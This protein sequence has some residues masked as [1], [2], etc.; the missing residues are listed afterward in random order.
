M[1]TKEPLRWLSELDKCGW[2]KDWT[3][4]VKV[5]RNKRTRRVS[6]MMRIKLFKEVFGKDV[7]NHARSAIGS[8]SLPLDVSVEVEAIVT[9]K[10]KE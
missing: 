7:G 8:N 3:D 2:V 9:I 6:F 1:L 5:A 10:P 4:T